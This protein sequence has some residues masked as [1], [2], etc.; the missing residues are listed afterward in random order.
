MASLCDLP[1]ELLSNVLTSFCDGKSISSFLI[2]AQGTSSLKSIAFEMVQGALVRRYK[3]LAA[4]AVLQQHPS[5]KDILDILREDIRLFKNDDEHNDGVGGSGGVRFAKKFSEYCAILDY[6][7]TQLQAQRMYGGQQPHHWILWCGSVET[8]FGF[9]KSYVTSPDWSM[10]AL[11]QWYRSLEMISF[12]LVR[13]NIA[14]QHEM[15]RMPFGTWAGLTENDT[16]VLKVLRGTVEC[17][18]FTRDDSNASIWQTPIQYSYQED[19]PLKFC[20]HNYPS[21]ALGKDVYPED[22]HRPNWLKEDETLCYYWDGGEDEGCDWDDTLD[23]L[24]ENV[25]RIMTRF[26]RYVELEDDTGKESGNTSFQAAWR[27]SMN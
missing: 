22:F 14:I 5:I 18:D 7:E 27:Q 24:G 23:L 12:S 20:G 13:P 2:V 17:D 3:D 10:E 26:C 19:A 15:E 11:H 9:I 6:F 16:A 1:M 4:Q 8:Q 25:I 21:W